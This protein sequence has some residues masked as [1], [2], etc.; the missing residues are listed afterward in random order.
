MKISAVT[1]CGSGKK[2]SED[3]IL[4]G[5]R[6]LCNE[7]FVGELPPC[8]VGIADGVGGNAGG[9]I[10]AQYIC[11]KL[12]MCTA[13]SDGFAAVNA[14]LLE[15]AY[16]APG[17]ETMASTFTGLFPNGMLLHIGNTRLY[18]IQGGYLKQLTRD[19]TT[20]NF[21]CACGRYEEAENCEKNEITA[22]FG[23]G[24]KLLF[25]PFIADQTLSGMAVIT[26]DGVHD[27]VE[28][29]LLEEILSSVDEDL[30]ACRRIV[31]AA[32]DNGSEDD[33]SVVV[34]RM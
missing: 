23:G 16:T 21:L 18:I 24:N 28:L 9:D 15:F 2:N 8:V 31:Q 27:H 34:V 7:E 14:S 3:R 30:S 1:R 29:D 6:I 26:S 13:D 32:V 11:E 4:V 22:C 12:S 10:A 19:M 25:K 20:Y 17:K 5:E 33:L